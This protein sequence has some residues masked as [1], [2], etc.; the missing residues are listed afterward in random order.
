MHRSTAP[1][2]AVTTL[3]FGCS[4]STTT[5]A[6]ECPQPAHIGTANAGEPD[7]EPEPVPVATPDTPD[8]PPE[9]AVASGLRPAD[10]FGLSSNCEAP[11]AITQEVARLLWAAA[12][13]G[14]RS[15]ACVDGR[16]HRLAI[17]DLLVCPAAPQAG[18]TMVDVFY[19][20]A[21]YPEGDTRMC[22]QPGADCSW[23]TPTATEHTISL[24]LRPSKDGATGTLV[25]V[26]PLPGFPEDMTP[27]DQEH[28]GN[29]YGSSPAFSPAAVPI[30]R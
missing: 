11:L 17:N 9:P 25:D 13:H 4:G 21:T 6:T 18:D 7:P 2:L 23:L 15:A 8:P 1:V 5:A 16:G 30:R 12:A 26:P 27:L 14:T 24:R 22:N 19:Q 10:A 3:I 28:S 29:C 20:V